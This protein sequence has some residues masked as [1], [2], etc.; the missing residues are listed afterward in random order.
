MLLIDIET[1]AMTG[2][3]DYMEPVEAPS[4]YKDPVKIASYIEEQTRKKLGKLAL[5]ADLCRIV[6]IGFES[7][8]GQGQVLTA[9]TTP[10]P[11]MLT[12]LWMAASSAPAFIGFNIL[13]FDLP[14]LIRRSQYLG[15]ALPAFAFN[16]DRYRTNHVDLMQRLTFNGML[17]FR[18]LDFYCKRFGI[19]VPD[20]HSG[21]DIEALVAANDWA[22]V[23]AHCRADLIKT[24]ALAERLGHLA[25][26]AV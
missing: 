23:E 11:I 12:E 9:N 26:V 22:A 3:G 25:A 8:D 1:V 6:A 4:N 2:A 15:V 18:S 17:D 16:L 20:P 5:D 21:K 13:H 10:E 19:D 24:R 7:E 14:V